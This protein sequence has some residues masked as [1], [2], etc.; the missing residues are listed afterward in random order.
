[1]YKNIINLI[2]IITLILLV[3]ISI[4]FAEIIKK[5]EIYGNER[6]PDETIIMFSG[7]KIDQNIEESNLNEILKNLYDSNFFKDISVNLSNNILS[8]NV[9]E[10]PIIEKVIY[11]GIKSKSLKKELTEKVKLK[12]RSSFN[13][14]DLIDD[15]IKIE[16]KL[17]EKGYYF[18]NIETYVENLE[19]NRINLR[20]EIDLGNKAKIKKISFVGN[21]IYK[22]RKLKGII[23]SEE[24]KFWKF[25]SGKKYL[26]EELIRFD[27]RL[28]KNFYLNKGYY[29]V[30]IN[31]SFA[32]L[33]DDDG[34]E[35]VYNIN[36]NNKFYF[37]DLKIVLP[38][39]FNKNNFETL[40]KTFA[41]LKGKPYSINSVEKILNKINK[42]TTIDEFRNVDA[43]V[44]EKIVSNKINLDFIISESEK[45]VLK[46]INIFGNNI[47]R[48]SVIRNQFELDEGDFYNEILKNKSINN[49][50]S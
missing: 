23:L 43:V 21:K 38:T 12:S 27:A 4:S 39:D 6:I 31:S 7:I 44:D 35:L 33:F 24:F 20:Y 34:F 8:I 16:S 1:M 13:N 5:I 11:D 3:N 49:L 47:T 14:F 37:N 45:I 15:K 36:A 18:A 25:I 40:T 48:E 30:R 46:K 28:L 10:N 2:S 19:N 9:I 29:D 22:D 42:I 17:K 32:K 41:D 50:K 26:N